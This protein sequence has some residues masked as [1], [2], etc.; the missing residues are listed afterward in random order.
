ML[1][2]ALIREWSERICGD[3]GF[4]QDRARRRERKWAVAFGTQQFDARRAGHCRSGRS[5]PSFSAATK[6]VD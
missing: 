4:H 2:V 6:T 5:T 1:P 3:A